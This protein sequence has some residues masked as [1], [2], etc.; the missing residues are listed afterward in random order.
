M[1]E[2]SARGPRS[3]TKYEQH[4]QVESKVVYAKAKRSPSMRMSVHA[5]THPKSQDKIPDAGGLKG[6]NWSSG[7]LK[8]V[9]VEYN[10]GIARDKAN[11]TFPKAAPTV[12]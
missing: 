4:A 1:S 2:I 12:T 9:A 3:A 10:R 6:V 8:P 7:A 5:V 11:A